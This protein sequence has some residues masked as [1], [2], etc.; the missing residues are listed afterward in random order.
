MIDLPTSPAPAGAEAALIDFGAFLTSPLGGPTQRVD[1]MGNRFR[2]SVTMPPMKNVAVGRIWVA[3]L[4]RGKSEG[5]RMRLPLQGFDPGLPGVPVVAGTGQTG[6]TL[7]IRAATPNA[8][9]RE[10]QF[11]SIVTGG[12]HHL[13]MVDAETIASA[14]GTATL[15]V[16]PMLRVPH[17]DGDAC[18]FGQPMIEGFVMGDEMAWQMQLARII[19]IAF[20]LVEAA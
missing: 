2:L 8:I 9:F 20:D 6:R 17:L 5:V 14:T 4:I 10:G 7:A 11:F 12:R 18:H 16:S 3:R 1:R 13:T 19:G 15:P